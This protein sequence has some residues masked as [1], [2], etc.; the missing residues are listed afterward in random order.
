MSTYIALTLNDIQ[1]KNP[2]PGWNMIHFIK[3]DGNLNC[4]YCM[5]M[6]PISCI[7]WAKLYTPPYSSYQY[8]GK[9]MTY[10]FCSKDC[11]DKQK[12]ILDIND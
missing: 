4:H 1:A 11:L 10:R 2:Y 7:T 8:K 5:K 6:L 9:M 12:K 3:E